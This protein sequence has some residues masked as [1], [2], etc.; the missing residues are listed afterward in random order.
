MDVQA[1]AVCHATLP[2]SLLYAASER[3]SHAYNLTW[4]ECPSRGFWHY[5]HSSETLQSQ[6][7]DNHGFCHRS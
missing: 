7:N 4:A 5:R 3:K 6:G 2:I 1:S